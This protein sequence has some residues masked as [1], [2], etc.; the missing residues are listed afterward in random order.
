METERLRLRRFTLDDAEAL[1]AVL[2]DPETMRYI[3]EPFSR[4]K[5]REFIAGA[6]LSEPPLVYALL[7]KESGELIGQVIYH[8]F[9][10]ESWELGWIIRRD[11]WGRGIAKELTAALIGDAKAKGRRALVI[12]CD[13]NQTVSRHIAETFGFVPEAEDGLAVYKLKL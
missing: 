4:K 13:K 8:P 1:Y 3:E 9:E 2:S 11:F 6:G 5:T 10:G 12:E 7:W